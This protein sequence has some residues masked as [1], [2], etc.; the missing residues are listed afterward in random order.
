M[1]IRTFA[2][3][4]A[5]LLAAAQP[6][7]VQHLIA[8]DPVA[9][10]ADD[11]AIW[12]N[13]ADASKSLII[14][15]NK[16]AAPKGALVV[17]GLDGKTR[18]VVAGLDRPNNVDIEYGFKLGRAS[19]DIAVTTER[20]KRRLLVHRVDSEGL[21]QIGIIPV[22]EGRSGEHGAP[23]GI[24]LYK[25]PRDG[26][27]FAIVAPKDGPRQ[28]YLV[29]YR[30]ES[31]DAG[32]VRGVKVRE[33]GRFSGSGE[34]EAVA[35]DDHLGYVY[36]ADEGDGLHKYHADP[37][38]PN[39]AH[40]LA[41]FAREGYRSDREGI[42]IYTRNNGTGYILSTDQIAGNSEIH[43]FPREGAPG[44][45]HQHDEIKVVRGRADTTDGLEVTSTPLGPRFPAGIMVAMNS[46]A[47]NFLMYRW[48]DVARAGPRQ[49]RE[50][51]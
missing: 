22:L 48:E 19:I 36:Y 20:L 37:D 49:L 41:W 16:V 34:I 25:R 50:R 27:I 1:H 4:G 7:D 44:R 51:R 28:D 29:Q 5:V 6:F 40:E 38:H 39:A 47:R 12:V 23:M 46:G 35:A 9:D 24:A 8:T 15:T 45:P 18:Q 3:A 32:G 13:P 17:F 11:P 2:F 30:I 31:D 14:G 42:A 33:F 43:I 26:V 10:D 21:R